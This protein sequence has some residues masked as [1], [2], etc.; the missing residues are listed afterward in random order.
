MHYR[1]RA[2]SKTGQPTIIPLKPDVVIGQRNSLSTQDVVAMN[3]LCPL[4]LKTHS[5]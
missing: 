2:F 3:K 1:R 4:N 5:C